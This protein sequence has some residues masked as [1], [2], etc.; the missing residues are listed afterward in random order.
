MI[1]RLP[2]PQF[3]GNAPADV[4]NASAQ[5]AQRFGEMIQN[6]MQEGMRQFQ[7][8]QAMQQ[9][10][11]LQTQ[12]EK[13]ASEQLRISLLAKDLSDKLTAAGP[14]EEGSVLLGNED[15]F[16][17]LFKFYAN[18][19]EDLANSMYEGTAKQFLG[20]MNADAMM[21]SGMLKLDQGQD[22]GSASPGAIPQPVV[23]SQPSATPTPST[24]NSPSLSAYSPGPGGSRL[25]PVTGNPIGSQPSLS[26]MPAS[27][28]PATAQTQPVAST[29][30]AHPLPDTKEEVAQLAPTLAKNTDLATDFSTYMKNNGKIKNIPTDPGK[31]ADLISNNPVSFLAYINSLDASKKL[32]LVNGAS[33]RAAASQSK[34]NDLVLSM[35]QVVPNVSQS[36]KDAATP[37]FQKVLD[38][39]L[40]QAAENLTPKEQAAVKRVNQATVSVIEDSPSYKAFIAA[41]GVKDTVDRASQALQQAIA[42]DPTILDYFNAKKVLGTRGYAEYLAG[43]KADSAAQKIAT[44]AAIAGRKLDNAE[45]NTALN[46]SKIAFAT[47][48][49]QERL[50]I[51]AKNADS[52]ALSSTENLTIAAMNDARTSWTNWT[53]DYRN[54]HPKAPDDEVRKAWMDEMKNE[55]SINTQAQ[56]RFSYLIAKYIDA[57]PN[58]PTLKYSVAQS[59]W[60]PLPFGMGIGEKP[61]EAVVVPG[62]KP[63]SARGANATANPANP[64]NTSGKSMSAGDL[65]KAGL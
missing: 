1:S 50:A 52:K 59:W 5:T 23:S 6:G 18:G 53:T 19:N 29:E 24:P 4:A 41:G 65:A 2:Q 12:A 58:D 17:T 37:G 62:G 39:L 60:L 43:Y 33:G 54:R 16:K 22:G 63:G 35:T 45:A 61:A 31:L 40:G 7:A 56:T 44:D 3:V 28:T 27:P 47:Q 26:A 36:V 55:G 14:G 32:A 30:L 11:K 48:T 21:K 42:N 15:Q 57:N 38:G 49:A 9:K 8:S 64:A 51:L 25:G 10:A 46:A 20:S 34:T 13:S